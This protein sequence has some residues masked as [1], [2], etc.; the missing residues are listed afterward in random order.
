MA[1]SG[2]FQF[3]NREDGV[4]LK[5]VADDMSNL[6]PIECLVAYCDRKNIP[7]TNIMELKDAINKAT[8]GSPVRISHMRVTA[9][10]GWADYGIS[11]DRMTLFMTLYP[12]MEGMP[13]VGMREVQG[14]IANLGVK[15]GVDTAAIQNLFDTKT[16]YEKTV[17]ARGTPPVDGYDAQLTYAFNTTTSTKPRINENGTV[18][19]HQLDLINKVNEGDVVANITPENPGTAG[20]NIHG[21]TVKPKKVYRKTF[22]Y[23]KNL[24]ISDD[25]QK[26]ITMVTGHVYLEGDK[27][28]VSSEYDIGADV[29]NSTGDINFDGNVRIRGTVRAGFKVK[30]TGNVVV[31]GMVEGAEVIAGGD[32][33]LQRGI[34]GMNKGVL[35]AGGN[36]AANFIENAI[37]K[38][39]KDI[40]ADAILHSNVS[41][42]GNIRVDGRNG[43]MVGGSIRAGKMIEA[44]FIGSQM[45]TATEVGVGTDPEVVARLAELKKLISKAVQDKE[46]LNQMLTLLRKR[47]ETEG[48]LDEEK[49]KLFQKTMKNVIQLDSQ[50]KEMRAEHEELNEKITETDDARIKITRTIYPGVKLEIY[51]TVYFIR[52]KNDYC[53]YVRQEGEIKRINL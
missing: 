24:K 32:I 43:L 51:N 12:P 27:V 25:G 1:Y 3:E 15:Y 22:K 45:E 7:Y 50:M 36:I 49:T 41:A 5:A 52:D 29:D 23:G 44:K 19:F 42:H 53:Q 17:I 18:D 40:E 10:A 38:A 14:D 9:F 6:P 37:A 2:F 13:D 4:Y 28:F 34:H 21:E 26:L 20:T 11:E 33:I 35:T 8:E 39:G 47:Q 48:R 31:D 46:M 16:Y 30:A